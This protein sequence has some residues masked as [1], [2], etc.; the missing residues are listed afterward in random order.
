[1]IIITSGATLFEDLPAKAFDQ[2]L[3]VNVS[4]W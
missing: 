2:V 3:A 4:G 1:M